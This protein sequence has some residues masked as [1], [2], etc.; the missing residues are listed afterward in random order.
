M[1]VSRTGAGRGVGAA[2]A[3][4]R[5]RAPVFGVHLQQTAALSQTSHPAGQVSP[6]RPLS[7]PLAQRSTFF[8]VTGS[9]MLLM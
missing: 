6:G 9:K 5:P 4:D 8:P 2:A 3:P 7:A 1:L